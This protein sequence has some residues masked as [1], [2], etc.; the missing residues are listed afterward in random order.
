MKRKQTHRKRIYTV[1][2]IIRD[3]ASNK[4]IEQ[5]SH[6]E[7]IKGPASIERHIQRKAS[8]KE[9]HTQEP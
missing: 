2:K 5:K 9:K 6:T 3:P 7:E 8:K 1:Q 4:K